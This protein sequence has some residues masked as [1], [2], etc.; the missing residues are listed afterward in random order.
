MDRRSFNRT[1]FCAGAGIPFL[2]AQAQQLTQARIVVGFT[3]GGPIDVLA[4]RVANKLRGGYAP[5]VIVENKPGAAGQIAITTTRDSAAD[6]STLL[7]T[8]SSMLSIYPFTYPKLPYSLN[9]LQPVSLACQMSHGFA[10]G[11]SVPE[12]IR[13]FG[14]FLRWA[15][16]NVTS[17]TLASPGAGSMPHLIGALLGNFTGADLRHV[18]YRG[19][20]PAVQDLLGGQ[21]A[22]FCGPTGDLIQYVKAGRVRMLLTSGSKRSI[23][24]PD[25]PTIREAGLPLAV[26]EWYGFFLPGKA[27]PEAA[28]KAHAYLLGALAQPDVVNYGRQ[29]A[30]EVESST[31]D[32]LAKMLQADAEQWRRLIKQIGFTA[33]S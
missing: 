19:S 11:P 26:N 17:A 5:A 14:D 24:W 8:P 12:T 9:D 22:A 18:P 7:L 6:G 20:L 27:S 21:V 3:A 25:V 2:P 29:S 4:R 30:L 31:P 15:K 10:V 33:E 13:T 16:D 32:A 23:F 28:R 1:L